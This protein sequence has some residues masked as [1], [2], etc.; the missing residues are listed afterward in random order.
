MPPDLRSVETLSPLQQSEVAHLRTRQF[1]WTRWQ[2]KFP[3]WSYDHCCL[4]NA[5]I[6][7]HRDNFP[8]E[9]AEHEL[10]GCYRHAYCTTDHT[11]RGGSPIWLCRNCYKRARVQNNSPS[12]DHAL[13][14]E[15]L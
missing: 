8:H 2:S 11:I 6:C 3:D 13:L 4:C 1:Q 7:Q 9:K 14:V 10:R 15:I 12:R 5:C